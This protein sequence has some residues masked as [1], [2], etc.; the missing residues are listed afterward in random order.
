MMRGMVEA[1]EESEQPVDP[2]LRPPGERAAIVG[3]VGRV[4]REQQLAVEAIGAA[5]V[6]VHAIENVRAVLQVPHV[7]RQRGEIGLAHSFSPCSMTGNG[8]TKCLRANTIA[9]A[10]TPIGT[11]SPSNTCCGA[12]WAPSARPPASGAE[13][14]PSRLTAATHPALVARK[15]SG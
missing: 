8:G 7:D 6:A 14:A 1:F 3:R 13:T 4:G 5:G 10:D 2:R 9:T 15:S 12:T 11:T